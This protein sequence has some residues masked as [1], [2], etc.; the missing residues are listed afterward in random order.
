[1]SEFSIFNIAGMAMSAQTLRLNTIAS[2]MAN[3]D[4]VG[5]SPE[6]TFRSLH[7]VF[8]P[9]KILGDDNMI[10]NGTL[11]VGVKVSDIM[12]S[13]AP[14]Q[15]TYDPNHPKADKEGYVY[16]SDVDMVKQMAD[17][18]SASRTFQTNAEMVNTVKELV[19][20]SL[21]LGK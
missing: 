11:G 5:D 18:V 2:N 15:K 8:A 16:M 4:S 1:M 13:D 7:P 9:V 12:R 14:L 3:A 6:G 21:T 20:Q 10:E 19:T 17:M